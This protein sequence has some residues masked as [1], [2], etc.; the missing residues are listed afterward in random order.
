MTE[1]ASQIATQGLEYL[2]TRYQPAPIPL[3]PIW[4]AESTPEQKLRI[5]G[6]ALFSG[7]LTRERAVWI[8]NA[9]PAQW[10][11]TQDRV[12][13]ENRCLTPLGRADILVKVLG[14]LV[15][16]EGIE[17]ELADLSAGKLAPGTFAVVAVADARAEHALVPVFEAA[18]DPRLMT[19]VLTVYAEQAPGFRQL[20]PPVLLAELPRSPLGKPCRAEITAAI[21]TSRGA[22]G[23]K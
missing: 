14:E 13:L 8:F 6:A 12:M 9:R 16:P 23:V 2:G 4:Q 5:A 17:R 11:Q 15:D 10:H 1:A 20:R 3:L 21:L 22:G 7:M 18:V 19:V